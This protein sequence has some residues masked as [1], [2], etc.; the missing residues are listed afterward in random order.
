MLA[1]ACKGCGAEVSAGSKRCGVC[2]ISRPG[3]LLR[4][5]VIRP[6]ALALLLAR[7]IAYRVS[8]LVSAAAR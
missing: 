5:S 1:L 3:S 8:A 7:V 2:G 6:T 4:V